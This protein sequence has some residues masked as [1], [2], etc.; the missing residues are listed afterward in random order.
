MD[1]GLNVGELPHGNLGTLLSPFQRNADLKI[2]RLEAEL[3]GLKKGRL[4]EN[5]AV[6]HS[7][8]SLEELVNSLKI[9]NISFFFK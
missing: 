8:D 4:M 6:M 3:A 1:L 7:Y 9:L 2:A 5:Q